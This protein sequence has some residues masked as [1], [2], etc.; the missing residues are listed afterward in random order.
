MLKNNSALRTKV[1]Q[2]GGIAEIWRQ[3]FPIAA[4]RAMQRYGRPAY[5]IRWQYVWSVS[6][7]R[8]EDTTT[9]PDTRPSDASP[10]T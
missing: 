1:K 7:W 10:S 4:G 6:L 9:R 8:L 5:N 3:N 2:K